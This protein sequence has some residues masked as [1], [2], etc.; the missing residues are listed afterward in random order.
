MI[1]KGI[2]TGEYDYSIIKERLAEIDNDLVTDCENYSKNLEN[3]TQEENEIA[4][5]TIELQKQEEKGTEAY[6]QKIDW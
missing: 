2:V 3:L 6:L 1:L 5:Q 4:K